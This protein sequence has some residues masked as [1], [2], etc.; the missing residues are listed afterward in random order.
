MRNAP[1]LNAGAAPRYAANGNPALLVWAEGCTWRGTP[2]AVIDFGFDGCLLRVAS[3]PPKGGTTWLCLAAAG[4][5]PWIGA[6]VTMTLKKGRFS[7]TRRLVQ[8][9]FTEPCPYDVFKAAVDGF[10]QSWS[11][12]EFASSR[13]SE[14]E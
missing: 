4:P 11:L 13:F 1:H 14:R 3:C 9:R 10:S 8:L 12:P 5:S 2:A 6:T 7:W